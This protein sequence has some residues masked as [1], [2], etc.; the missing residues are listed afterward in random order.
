MRSIFGVVLSLTFVFFTAT[1]QEN[2]LLNPGFEEV[3]EKELPA[4]WEPLVIGAPASFA[5]DALEKHSG[6]RSL[7]ITATETAR[8]YI[9]SHPIPVVP[10]EKIRCSAWV[11]HKDVPPGK[12]TVIAIAEF[13]DA[14]GYNPQVAK[15]GVADTSAPGSQWRRVEGTVQAPQLAAFLRLR[16]GFSYAQGTCWWDDVALRFEQPLVARIDLASPRMSP[17][18][19]AVPVVVLNRTRERAQVELQVVAGKQ[20]A[21]AAAQLTGEPVQRL[22]VPIRLAERSNKLAVETALLRDG[23]RLYTENRDVFVPP[24]LVLVPPIPTHW[25]KEDPKPTLEARVEL[26]VSIETLRDATLQAKLIDGAGATQATWSSQGKELKD[27][28]NDFSL[29]AS[30]LP[31]AEYTLVVELLPKDGKTLRAEQPWPVIPRRLA[32]VTLNQDGYPVCDGQ[33]LFP[34]GVFNGGARMKEMGQAGFTVSH[35]Y[36]A[37]EAKIGTRPD[38][39]RAKEFLDNSHKAGLKAL[40]LVPRNLAFHGD[41]DGVRRRIRMFRNHPG[42]LAWDEEEGLARGDIK[43][44]VLQQLHDIVRQE[45][46]NHPIMVGD[47]RDV[48]GRMPADR[49]DFFPLKCMDMGMWWWYPLPLGGEATALEGDEG[50]RGTELVPPAFLVN[51]N[52]DK[53]IW[54]G[55]QAYKKPSAWA[56]YPNPTEYRAQA[57]IAIAHGARG[58]MW[59]GGSVT[60][61]M[62]LKPDEARWD[63]VQTLA[64]ELRELSPVL[65]GQTLAAPKFS[66]SEAPVSVVL[67]RGGNRLVLIATNRGAKPVT[68]TLTSPELR[69]GTVNVLTENRTL[70]VKGGAIGDRFEPYGVHVYQQSL[71]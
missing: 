6:Q 12:G 40:M 53:P 19:K 57:Y 69:Y 14:N 66:P 27:G 31:E 2:L 8:S 16:L 62:Y 26:A 22:E 51:R 61:G 29:S 48:I 13:T 20:S 64:K 46:P 1:A 11:K 32:R 47:S 28:P 59:Y 18:M 52:T 55:V 35:A 4:Q 17:A 21:K 15:I 34:L 30:E 36:N 43:L 63:Y 54:V 37:V 67:K 65:L 33:P 9:R 68:L 10:G 25:A 24:P 23:K 49:A 58:L 50:P 71:P 38:D 56:R 39:A 41:W 3:G 5:F 70:E 7:R 44:G 45:D 60:G 42:L